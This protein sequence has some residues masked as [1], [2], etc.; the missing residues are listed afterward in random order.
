[1]TTVTRV[2]MF[3]ETLL[4][5]WKWGSFRN[6]QSLWGQVIESRYGGWRGLEERG[7]G[8]NSSIWW[9]DLRRV[10]GEESEDKWFDKM[11]VEVRGW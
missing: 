1:M 4:A 5:K 6:D 7:G 9:R 3:N 10:C 11:S 8:R 2:T